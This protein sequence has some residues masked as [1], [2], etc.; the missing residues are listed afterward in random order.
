MFADENWYSGEPTEQLGRRFEVF[1]NAYGLCRVDT[2]SLE[3]MFPLMKTTFLKSLPLV[4][5]MDVTIHYA[6]SPEE[7]LQ[8]LESRFIDERVKCVN[9]DGWMELLFQ[10]VKLGRASRNQ[11]TTH[12]NF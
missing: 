1:L 10:L 4:Y 8:M 12:E 3:V 11:E 2:S 7:A 6:G 9:D 5:Y